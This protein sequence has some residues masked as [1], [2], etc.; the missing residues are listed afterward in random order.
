MIQKQMK[1][2]ITIQMGPVQNVNTVENLSGLMLL[3][4]KKENGW[5]TNC[6]GNKKAQTNENTFNNPC[7]LIVRVGMVCNN[8][9]PEQGAN[10][11]HKVAE[12][13]KDFFGGRVLP[14]HDRQRK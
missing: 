1:M 13:H 2:F 14:E 11:H 4:G 8:N 3:D 9:V 10:E 12:M 5:K 6:C 7:H